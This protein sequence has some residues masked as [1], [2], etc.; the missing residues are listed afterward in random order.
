M[1]ALFFTGCVYEEDENSR[2]IPGIY[3]GSS[4]LTYSHHTQFNGS[5]PTPI[6]ID[7]IVNENAILD[8]VAIH[9]GDAQLFFNIA[10][11]YIR[12]NILEANGFESVSDTFAGATYSSRGIFDAARQ[13]ILQATR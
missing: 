11:E 4:N 10:F 1:A 3:R 8:V 12:M 2:F 6:V 5:H 7:V 9:H 13:A